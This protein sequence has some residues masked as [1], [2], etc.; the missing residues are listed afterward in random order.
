ML[1]DKIAQISTILSITS[2][3]FTNP[4]GLSISFLNYSSLQSKE[5]HPANSTMNG[6]ENETDYTHTRT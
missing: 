4:P 1:N 2:L 3:L 6:D 5:K